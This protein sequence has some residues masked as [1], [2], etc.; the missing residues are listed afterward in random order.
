MRIWVADDLLRD[1]IDGAL[2]KALSMSAWRHSSYG[3]C[4]V[5]KEAHAIVSL[6]RS[7]AS[8]PPDIVGLDIDF[9][10]STLERRTFGNDVFIGDD[11]KKRSSAPLGWILA[12]CVRHA[13]SL[14]R[15]G[16]NARL[17]LYSGKGYV[18]QNMGLA[19]EQPMLELDGRTVAPFIELCGKGK[20]QDASDDDV[21]ALVVA[22]IREMTHEVARE[23][24]STL[25]VDWDV[26]DKLY[27][28]RD[29]IEIGETEGVNTALRDID[30]AKLDT[31][32]S[33]YP[34]EAA[35]VIRNC[36]NDP[37][38]AAGALTGI[39]DEVG[40]CDGHW[41]LCK[42]FKTLKGPNGCSGLPSEFRT[43]RSCG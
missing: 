31:I 4:L 43:G 33:L 10:E 37:A 35:T 19:V 7:S 14:R 13:N 42:A 34:F 12:A 26:I 20:A 25:A 24:L 32:F 38:A 6:L 21:V 30:D 40:S 1:R 11:G 16:H 5:K 15:D 8:E 41:E 9:V 36:Q 18:W 2:T 17:F 3:E 22:K 27:E 28:I 23:R 29:R 39:L